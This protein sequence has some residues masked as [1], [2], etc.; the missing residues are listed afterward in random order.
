M[1]HVL[2]LIHASSWRPR[3]AGWAAS[4]LLQAE[5]GRGGA[6]WSFLPSAPVSVWLMLAWTPLAVLCCRLN[7]GVVELV[8]DFQVCKAG[9]KLKPN[10]VRP[11]AGGCVPRQWLPRRIAVQSK[12]VRAAAARSGVSGTRSV[13]CRPPWGPLGHG[14]AGGGSGGSPPRCVRPLAAPSQAALL[15][16]FDVK[17]AAFTMKLLALWENDEVKTLAE[18]DDEEGSEG[19]DAPGEGTAE[20]SV[21]ERWRGRG[22]AAPASSHLTQHGLAVLG[23]LA[24]EPICAVGLPLPTCCCR[25]DRI[26]GV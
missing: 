23:L 5:H 12:H 2:P 17:Q 25:G 19:E 8:A 15:R 16:I 26:S 22:C 10:Q 11:G 21:Q 20:G 4:P 9:Q 18:D 14:R 24:G 7:K 6:W 1:P 3:P 13:A